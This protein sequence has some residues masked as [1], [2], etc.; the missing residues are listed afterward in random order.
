AHWQGSFPWDD[1]VRRRN[2]YTFG[3]QGGFRPNQ[4]ETI[5]A[6]LSKRDVFL[7]M[8]TGGGKSLCYQIPA[9]VNHEARRGGTTVV[10]CPLVSLILDQETQ[11][12]QCGILCAGLT[13]STAHT[14]P[15]AETFKKLFSAKLRVLFVTPERLS[16]SKRLLDLL[17]G[18]YK[19]N[20][21]HGFVVDE[22]HCVS[23]WGHDFRE[24]YLQL[25]NIR[26]TF[27]GV[28]IL[29]MT[30]TA[31][32]EIIG[33]IM[34]QLGM[35]SS[36]TVVIRTSLNRANISYAVIRKPPKG[37][38]LEALAAKIRELGGGG[39]SGIVYC[40]SKKD[41]DQVCT[42]LRAYNIK[43]AVYHADLPQTTR[44][45]NQKLWMDNEVQVMVATVAFGMG[46]NKRDVRFVI[47][48]SMPK[49]LEAFYQESGRAGR[50]GR[51]SHS[52]IYYD[53]Y[54]KNR[55]QWLIEQGGDGARPSSP[56]R[57]GQISEQK[58]SLLA[59]VAYCESSTQCRRIILLKYLGKEAGGM[60]ACLDS[61]SLPCDV[62]VEQ[63]QAGLSG[64]SIS[65]VPCEA[66]A[67]AIVSLC[68]EAVSKGMKP[69]LC[70]LKDAAI[71]SNAKSLLPAWRS[72]PSFACLASN[73][74]PF[75]GPL[76]L[77][78]L[79][80]MVVE[81]VL[82]EEV[83]SIGT[84]GTFAAYVT[85]GDRAACS[86]AAIVRRESKRGRKTP[87]STRKPRSSSPHSAVGSAASRKGA[88]RGALLRTRR[89]L[90]ELNGIMRTDAV[91]SDAVIDECVETMP[92]S[93][94]QLSTIQGLGEFRVEAYGPAML[95]ALAEYAVQA[96]D[97][98]RAAQ[99]SQAPAT[100]QTRVGVLS[101]EQEYSAIPTGSNN[102]ARGLHC[103]SLPERPATA[104]QQ[105]QPCT[106]RV[107]SGGGGG[108]GLG[109]RRS[110]SSLT[111]TPR[112]AKLPRQSQG[113]GPS[114]AA[115]QE[116]VIDICSSSD[117]E[118]SEA[119]KRPPGGF[120]SEQFFRDIPSASK[121][122]SSELRSRG[123]PR[124]AP[125]VARPR[126][127][128]PRAAVAAAPTPV[129]VV[130]KE[131]KTELTSALQNGGIIVLFGPP[132]CGKHFLLRAVCEELGLS[133]TEYR[134]KGWVRGYEERS[135]TVR[136][137]RTPLP[138]G[139]KLIRESVLDLMSTARQSSYN[140]GASEKEVI[141]SLKSGKGRVV[142]STTNFRIVDKLRDSVPPGRLKVITFRPI[143]VTGVKKILR[144]KVAAMGLSHVPIALTDTLAAEARGDG[145]FAL[146]Q[147]EAALAGNS[148]AARGGGGLKD[149]TFDYFHALGKVLYCKRIDPEAP[150]KP[151]AQ[152]PPSKLLPK[153][154]R[155]PPYFD[156]EELCCMPDW[157]NDDTVVNLLHENYIDFYGDIG[158]AAEC[159]SRL[160]TV[161][162]YRCSSSRP[163]RYSHT[164]DSSVG[165]HFV[166]SWACRAVMDSNCHPVSP[167]RGGLHQFRPERRDEDRDRS[168]FLVHVNHLISGT[169][170][171]PA[172]AA[173]VV[174][175]FTDLC[176]RATRGEWPRL[177]DRALEMVHRLVT[178]GSSSP[179]WR[180]YREDPIET[181][182]PQDDLQLDPI[183]ENFDDGPTQCRMDLM[184]DNEWNDLT[185][186]EL[187]SIEAAAADLPGG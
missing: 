10:I 81:G 116:S 35:P 112:Y 93:L 32:P 175:P 153:L 72:L 5:N 88:A 87:R 51:P 137:L 59:L 168:S 57:S 173:T 47:H 178:D 42:E 150:E 177:S 104:W 143:S 165:M 80:S 111:K 107:R 27:P 102:G 79:R 134:S 71:G 36:S 100:S 38:M 187:Q 159:I 145:R 124:D 67:M 119:S 162:A 96:D 74:P 123:P 54:S 6:V 41:C 89:K 139:V 83:V 180:A 12:S 167:S 15:P 17:A 170:R 157:E 65:E 183:S 22:A 53:Y 163:W 109:A 133:I 126:T 19:N 77:S 135:A 179:S 86:R 105:P 49:T 13:S 138:L 127:R 43:A 118:Q 1:E 2:R 69:T 34:A 46:I 33:D 40:M 152:L 131:R 154:N 76:V 120:W 45:T 171:S 18:L 184:E 9:L 70:S 16:A 151:P 73:D 101:V 125:K 84:H 132:G 7:V 25:A 78:L 37:K 52:V 60:M 185:E 90:S 158:D 23:Q 136:F 20:L 114:S 161:D 11:L 164:V 31:K 103:V 44:D 122:R 186:E 121:Q 92:T 108:G 146:N 56:G 181:S 48:Y 66:E 155:L 147:L 172:L 95:E 28:P 63:Q 61:G 166:S 91:F 169:C 85:V 176:L 68:D 30:A 128:A 99:S 58:R 144:A 106:V 8:P 94:E 55:N 117:E 182:S 110:G 50:D 115:S 148:V 142:M 129:L 62:C 113:Q 82:V 140:G 141:E 160:S 156:V 14:M 97:H 29:A 130:A 75:S 24:D 64:E 174:V 21:L 39:G 26:K 98:A 4:L 149:N 3:N